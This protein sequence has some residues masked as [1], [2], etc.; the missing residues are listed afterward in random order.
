MPTRLSSAISWKKLHQHQQE[1]VNTS[2]SELFS[3]NA[4]RAQQFSMEAA[5]LFLDYSKNLVTEDSLILFE[6]LAEECG[7]ASARESLR[8]GN[9]VNFTENRPALH[10]ALRDRNSP[11]LYINDTDIIAEIN[12]AK[13][14]MAGFVDNLHQGNTLGGSGKRISDVVNIGI[15]GSYLGPKLVVEALAPYQQEKV[16]CHFVANIDGSEISEVLKPLNP[17]TTLFIIASK[18]FSTQETLSNAIAAREWVYQNSQLKASVNK[19]FVAVSSNIPA[20]IEFGIEE[21]NIFPMWDWVGGRYSLWS[22]I[23]L[24]IAIALGMDHFQALLDGAHEMDQH[25][26]T[27]A[28]RDN[29]PFLLAMLQIWYNNF[30]DAHSQAVVPYDHSL[31]SLPEYLQQLEMESNGK[32]VDRAGIPLDYASGYAIWGGPGANGQHAYHQLFH[33]GTQLIP[34][35]FIFPLSTHNPVNDHHAMLISNCLSQSRA[36]LVGKTLEQASHE[37]QQQGLA[38]EEV[39]KLAPHKVIPGN[40]PSNT[41][42]MEKLTPANL[43][44][45][46]ALYEHKV[47]AQSVIWDINTFDQWGVELG[48]QI[49]KEIYQTLSSPEESSNYDSSTNQLITRFKAANRQ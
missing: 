15:G 18:S 28:P 34:V 24:P 12:K 1:I 47:F 14:K 11:P 41:I 25:F 4:Q 29:M 33:Q 39:R 32:R 2:L 44:S 7:F 35:D 17:E 8:Q 5:G 46:I 31:R 19:H 13:I 3:N 26:F 16:R 21:A 22:T 48:K 6:T 30:F 40:R 43:G 38:N 23:G 49:G 20:A 9:P 37:L 42:T 10:T 45:L 36:L 27:A